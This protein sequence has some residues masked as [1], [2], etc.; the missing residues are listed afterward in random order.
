MCSSLVF[1][2]RARAR[3]IVRLIDY[4][5]FS[6][7]SLRLNLRCESLN[8]IQDV[9]EL[10]H[11]TTWICQSER[12]AFCFSVYFFSAAFSPRPKWEIGSI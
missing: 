11:F 2:V 8:E 3:L 10:E 12:G 7:V 6:G 1:N 4:A 5:S 9:R